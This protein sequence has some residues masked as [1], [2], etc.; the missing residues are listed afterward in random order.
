MISYLYTTEYADEPQGATSE[1]VIFNVDMHTIA[2][3]YNIHQLGELAAAKFKVRA[4][5]GWS[6]PGFASA[7]QQVY[8]LNVKDDLR[9]RKIILEIAVE[10]SEALCT[11][12]C[13][14][15]FVNI[16]ETVPRFAAELFKRCALGFTDERRYT[17]VRCVKSF[18]MKKAVAHMQYGCP[19]CVHQFHWDTRDSALRFRE[20]P[21]SER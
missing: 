16:M 2:D 5:A 10:H 17:C 9:L 6:T 8:G 4:T 21:V 11:P 14:A 3:K 20:R 13:G 7:I 15:A 1:A 18:T 12:P 19:N